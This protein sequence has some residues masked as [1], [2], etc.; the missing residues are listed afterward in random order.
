MTDPKRNAMLSKQ[1]LKNIKAAAEQLR[2]LSNIVGVSADADECA[3]DLE[4]LVE[5]F[6]RRGRLS[7]RPSQ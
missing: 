1:D 5:R 2:H 7:A 4:K 3:A 6:E